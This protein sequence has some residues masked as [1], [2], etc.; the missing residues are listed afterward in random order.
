M[1]NFTAGQL[2]LDG[3]NLPLS[4]TNPF[5]LGANNTVTGSNKLSL[6]LKTSAGTFGGSVL[7]PATG[8]A[9]PVNGVLLQNL[10]SGYGYFAGTN[11]IGRV[12]LGP[13]P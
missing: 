7:N 11:Q 13:A 3:G 2:W 4:L 5:V 1:L 12:T 8:K 9:I 10:N 6:R